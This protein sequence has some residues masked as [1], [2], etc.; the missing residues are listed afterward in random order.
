MTDSDW[1]A[2]FDLLHEAGIDVR[3]QDLATAATEWIRNGRRFGYPQCCIRHFVLARLSVRPWHTREV[4]PLDE[5][6]M[7]DQC[8][9]R[10]E[11]QWPNRPGRRFVGVQGG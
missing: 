2:V 4:H 3:D 10:L 1:F 6:R 11:Q 7:C 9:A 8:A 5:R